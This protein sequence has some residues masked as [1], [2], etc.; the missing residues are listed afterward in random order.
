MYNFKVITVAVFHLRMQMAQVSNNL[1]QGSLEAL[2]LW[3]GRMH[4]NV[5]IFSSTGASLHVNLDINDCRLILMLMIDDKNFWGCVEKGWWERR[6]ILQKF[7]EQN[8][9][10]HTNFWISV[11]N[12]SPLTNTYSFQH[13]KKQPDTNFT[14]T[15]DTAN[16]FSKHIIHP[17]CQTTISLICMQLKIS[18]INEL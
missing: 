2:H 17:H 10:S 7:I 6:E 5:R 18:L 9:G 14:S 3:L 8:C 16:V 12:I 1:H 4:C 11:T 15:T 13:A